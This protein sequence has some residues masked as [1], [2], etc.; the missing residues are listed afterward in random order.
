MSK[1]SSWNF[2]STELDGVF[3]I[4]PFC[5]VDERGCFVKDYNENI[6][7]EKGIDFVVKETCNS[8]SKK[9]V[10]RGL[11]F[12]REKLMPKLVRCM[13]G[14]ILDVVC[15]LREES[16]TFMKY[17]KFIL[18][19]ENMNELY[20]PGGFAHGFLALED[21]LFVYKSGEVFVSE[22]DDGVLWCDE[23]LNIDWGIDDINK[24]IISEK[25]RNLQTFEEFREKY[26][27]L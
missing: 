14:K 23:T 24:I 18:S 25:D 6:F 10:L 21:S 11:H 17:Q 8:F 3:L 26:G 13:S 7:K 27:S 5:A 12:Q 9:N 20:I 16:P 2:K 22:Y 15:D 1:N 4:E 19:E